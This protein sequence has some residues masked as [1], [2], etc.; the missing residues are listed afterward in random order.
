MTSVR[1]PEAWVAHTC[2]G[3]SRLRIPERRH[4]GEYF[5]SIASQLR[6]CNLITTVQTNPATASIVILHHGELTAVA[7]FAV[8]SELFTLP[9]LANTGDS[10][11]LGASN[12]LRGINTIVQ[13]MTNGVLDA[14]SL[15]YAG[16]VG[17]ALVQALR[18]HVAGPATTLLWNA[19]TLAQL[20][21]LAKQVTHAVSRVTPRQRND[22]E[23]KLPA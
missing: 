2:P 10:A 14:P 23:Q 13:E 8:A 4:D 18:G 1:L 15:A 3:R 6:E 17:L 11:L 21:N 19:L 9:R 12:G 7:Q 16:L 20:G 5:A 22:T